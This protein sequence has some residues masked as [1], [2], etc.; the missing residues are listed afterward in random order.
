[1]NPTDILA[2]LVG[3]DSVSSLQLAIIRGSATTC[4]LGVPVEI[5]AHRRPA[6]A[7]LAR[8]ARTATAA[9]CSAIPTC[10]GRGPTL[11]S[12][13]SPCATRRPLFARHSDMKASSALLALV[14]DMLKRDL[15]TPLISP[16]PMTKKSLLGRASLIAESASASSSP[17]RHHRRADRAQLGTA[18]GATPSPDGH[19]QDGHSSSG[20]R[21]TPS[22]P[23]RK[24]HEL[25]AITTG[26]P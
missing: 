2:R 11:S 4:E 9:S 19:R 13:P 15:K 21:S 7:I 26:S 16:S 5:V 12:D 24:S 10:A 8:S 20:A 14:P 6:K 17:H 3:F 23:Q 25:G 22:S 18:Q 1:V